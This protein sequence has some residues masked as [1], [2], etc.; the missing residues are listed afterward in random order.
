MQKQV[1]NPPPWINTRVEWFTEWKAAW[2]SVNISLCACVYRKVMLP[3][4]GHKQP[5]RSPRIKQTLDRTQRSSVGFMD[6]LCPS[7]ICDTEPWQ[8]GRAWLWLQ[9]NLLYKLSAA[10]GMALRYILYFSLAY[11]SAL[12]RCPIASMAT[13][14]YTV[15]GA[16]LSDGERSWACVTCHISGPCSYAS[17]RWLWNLFSPVIM[18]FNSLLGAHAIFLMCGHVWAGLLELHFLCVIA[19]SWPLWTVFLC[20]REKRFIMS[21][22]TAQSHALSC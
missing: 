20:R 22:T 21:S 18:P 2:K 13:I 14:M 4:L 11:L 16:C 15:S 7:Q 12:H 9:L 6:G 10:P 17:P 19:P 8:G 3:P 1:D 5:I